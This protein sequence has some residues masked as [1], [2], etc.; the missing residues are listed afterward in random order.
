MDYLYSTKTNPRKFQQAIKNY[1]AEHPEGVETVVLDEKGL[2][3]DS[4]T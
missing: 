2:V 1:R 3:Y 4:Q